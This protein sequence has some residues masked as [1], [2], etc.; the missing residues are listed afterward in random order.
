[1]QDKGAILLRESA[2]KGDVVG[3]MMDRMGDEIEGNNSG[4]RQ[5]WWVLV[6]SP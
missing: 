1:M 4:E 3:S 6:Q 5:K 2:E